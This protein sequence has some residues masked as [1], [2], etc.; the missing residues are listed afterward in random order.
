[1]LGTLVALW[2]LD[3]KADYEGK[4]VGYWVDKVLSG[5][6]PNEDVETFQ[7]LRHIG[8]PAAAPLVQGI[9]LGAPPSLRR[10]VM[11][12]CGSSPVPHWIVLSEPDHLVLAWRSASNPSSCPPVSC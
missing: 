10:L 9:R 2:C 1:M 4:P 12:S 3:R 5:L 8:A 7:A 6:N 11:K